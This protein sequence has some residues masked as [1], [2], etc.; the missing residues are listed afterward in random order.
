MRVRVLSTSFFFPLDFDSCGLKG[1]QAQCR[2]SRTAFHQAPHTSTRP[3]LGGLASVVG[4]G[5]RPGDPAALAFPGA[6][7]TPS[8]APTAELLDP[9]EARPEGGAGW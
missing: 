4:W 3:P 6:P 7:R 8:E 5:R 2:N 9:W 1:S